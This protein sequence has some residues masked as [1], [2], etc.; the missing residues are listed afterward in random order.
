MVLVAV[1]L[2][3]LQDTIN[4]AD[5]GEVKLHTACINLYVITYHFPAIRGNPVS[6]VYMK[7]KNAVDKINI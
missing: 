7:I 2:I 5:T 1:I 4:K 3:L 6:K